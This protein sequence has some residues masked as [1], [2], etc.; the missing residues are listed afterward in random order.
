MIGIRMGKANGTFSDEQISYSTGLGS[1]P[2][3]LTLGDFDQDNE[4]DIAVA[5]YG[6]NNI[7]IFF[8][9]GNGWFSRQTVVSTGSSRPVFITSDDI[10]SDRRLDIVVVN[11]GTNTV[12]VF[13]GHGDGTFRESI[14]HWTGDDSLPCAVVIGDFNQDSYLDIAVANRGTNEIDIALGH[15][16]GTFTTSAIYSTGHRSSPTSIAVGD[17]NH[18]TKLDLVVAN[19]GTGRIAMLLG[20]GD[21]TFAAQMTHPLGS[22]SRPQFLTTGYIDSDEHL[23]IVIVDSENDYVHILPGSGNGSFAQLTTYDSIRGSGPFSAAVADFDGNNRS[24]IA[25]AYLDAH[26]V[27]VLSGYST[28]PS[29][30]QANYVLGRNSRPSSLAL[31]DFNHDGYL[32]AVVNNFDKGYL[33]MFKG[34]DNGSLVRGEAYATGDRSGPKQICLGDLNRDSI[35]DIIV[36]NRGSDSVGILFGKDNETFADVVLLSTG[37]GSSP[38]FVAV[39]DVNND[40]I[41]DIISANYGTGSIGVFLGYGDGTFTGMLT[42]S[43]GRSSYPIS[44]A[45]ADINH[46]RHPDIVV[47]IQIPA[48]V[49]IFLGHGNGSFENTVVYSFGVNAQ[50]F[51]TVLSDLDS[52]GQLDLIIVDNYVGILIF[53]GQG[54]GTF[55]SHQ[56]YSTGSGAFPYGLVVIDIDRDRHDDL[57]VTNTGSDEVYILF[58]NGDGTF[59][60]TRSYATGTDSRPYSLAVADLDNDAQLEIVVTLWGKGEVSVL[61][62]YYAAEFTQQLFYETG[63]T[64]HPTSAVIGDFNEDNQ[65][66]IVVTNSGTDKVDILLGSG[67]GTFHTRITYSLAKDSSPQYVMVDDVNGDRH[68]DVI[69][70][71]AMGNT[72]NIILGFGNGSFAERADYPTGDHSHPS[73]VAIGDFNN[74]DR[75]DLV[76]ANTGTDSIGIYFGYIYASF[77][78]Q[79]TYS[80][81]QSLGASSIAVDDLNN[82]GSLDIAAT[83]AKSD[84]LGILFG[85]GDGTFAEM[86]LYPLKA[87]SHPNHLLIN[88]VNSDGTKD[89]IVANFGTNDIGLLLGSGDGSFASMIIFP[90]G[91]ASYPRFVAVG[92][93]N[94]DHR[95]DMIIVEPGRYGIS[96]YLGQGNTSFVHTMTYSSGSSSDPYAVAIGDFNSDSQLDIVVANAGTSN[97]GILLGYGNGSFASA[98]MYSTSYLSAPTCIAIADFNNDNRSDLAVT[99]FGGNS[100]AILLGYGNGSFAA[101]KTYSTGAGSVPLY[102]G[103]ADFNNDSIIDIAVANSYSNS[104]VV[105]FGLGDGSFLAGKPYSTGKGSSPASLAIGDFDRD[106]RIDIA[107]ANSQSNSIGVFFASDYEPF[108]VVTEYGTGDSSQPHAVG[109]DDF[110]HDGNWDIAVANFGANNLG[111]FLGYGNGTF[112]PMMLYSTGVGSAPFSL[113]IADFN[114]D[115]HSDIAVTNSQGN[116][117]AVFLGHG[118]CLFAL[119]V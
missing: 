10:N 71:N 69:V 27:L 13:L 32:D 22:K 63:S 25:I 83:F 40:N 37:S 87:G 117:F 111:I 73:A 28:R 38:W 3:S 14:T 97:V 88:D 18:D 11:N 30:R 21:G 112:D 75:L 86:I 116:A 50:P 82:D 5:N 45:I 36:A 93:F 1:H 59:D 8:G 52:N 108:S 109:V 77:H 70:V 115:N 24:D 96:V 90:T 110:N 99:T 34:L 46:D 106:R 53:L 85:R 4:T 2:F 95:V 89:I 94:N 51:W 60:S 119:S 78:D 68:L 81:D 92:D 105:L 12:S 103:V 58:G 47:S 65:P 74:D 31:Y 15:G 43:T 76:V 107:V 39:E 79:T 100:V 57:V 80:S 55:Q 9:D 84:R 20:H 33:L 17:F 61:T 102:S 101:A 16:N 19:Y 49:S 35:M 41:L 118:K 67:N 44:L 48:S 64:A 7:V 62:D 114:S 56:N 23:D 72:I 6:A 66:D 91:D 98:V 42:Y 54:D 113:V 104:I 29:A 26:Q